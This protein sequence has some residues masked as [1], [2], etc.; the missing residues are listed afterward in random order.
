MLR[1]STGTD[2]TT[3]GTRIQ[4]RIDA[5]WMAYQQFNGTSVNG[6]IEWGTGLTTSSFQ[7]ILPRMRLNST[8]V[9][10]ILSA[11]AASSTTTGALVVNGGVGVGGNLYVGGTIVGNI[12]GTLT[13]N[14]ATVSTLQGTTNAAHFITFVD[15]NNSSS[16]AETIYT[17]STL[18]IN[19]STGNVGIGTATP[20]SVLHVAGTTR[21]TGI[22]TVT[23]TTNATSTTTGALQV[24]G[25]VGIGQDVWVGGGLFAT[26]KSFVINHP[27]KP[28]MKLRYGSLEGPE[29]GVYVR[30]RL[31][32][33]NTIILPDYW[34][35]LVD[36][37]SITVNL[38]PI[39]RHQ[40]LYVEDISNNTVT[41]GNSNLLN[42]EI[43]CFYTVF[44]ERRDVGK[45][46]VEIF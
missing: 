38:T 28:G 9:L 26:T 23:N 7:A 45:L 40:N 24:I 13:G 4:Q 22:T 31:N 46:E 5:T 2:W 18:V 33:S 21:I 39:G 30:G 17:T 29:N 14:A 10:S 37:N 8:G 1:D 27:T 34:T 42:K 6:G 19:P 11:A 15:S 35:N 25:G 44:A 12:S 3:A 20:L 32:G 36:A 16:S 41:V 43:N